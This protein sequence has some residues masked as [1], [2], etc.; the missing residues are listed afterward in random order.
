MVGMERIYAR[1]PSVFG[2]DGLHVQCAKPS[3]TPSWP[4]IQQM[5]HLRTT[6]RTMGTFRIRRMP[7]VVFATTSLHSRSLP[8]MT[9]TYIRLSLLAL[10]A[11]SLACN[12]SGPTIPQAGAAFTLST[13]GSTTMELTGT[14]LS[15]PTQV[16][17]YRE[18]VNGREYVVDLTPVVLVQ[19]ITTLASSS[20]LTMNVFG[21]LETGTY[22]VHRE[23]TVPSATSLQARL[24]VPV[25]ADHEDTFFLD[26]GSITVTSLNPFTATFRFTGTQRIRR[27]REVQI[28]QSAT[29]VPAPITVT[30]RIGAP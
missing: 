15:L 3:V 29:S 28:G 17:A 18:T 8:T 24:I 25:G 9:R 12:D 16:A 13:A 10:L 7:P 26:D 2:R 11:I 4:L 21:R 5:Q 27:P 6:M 22:R 19:S 30:G 14:T 23:G 1:S 20:Q